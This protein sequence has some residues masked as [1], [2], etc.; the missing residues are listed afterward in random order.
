[1]LANFVDHTRILRL[2]PRPIVAF[3]SASFLRSR[4]KQS[5]FLS[6]FV[7]TQAVECFAEWAI[8][9]GNV[10][11]QRVQQ[12]VFDPRTVGDK[13]KWFSH[14]LECL[15]WSAWDDASSLNSVL[16]GLFNSRLEEPATDES[17][18]DSEAALPTTSTSS[19]SASSS[20]SSLS[21]LVS[22]LVSGE[23]RGSTQL[24]G[25]EDA[26]GRGAAASNILP[27]GLDVS[28]VYRPPKCLQL[29]DGPLEEEDS[30]TCEAEV[31]AAAV[32]AAPSPAADAADAADAAADAADAAKDAA[33]D[34]PP[35]S[36]PVPAE[37]APKTAAPAPISAPQAASHQTDLTKDEAKLQQEELE[38]KE[39]VHE[40]SNEKLRF[41]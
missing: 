20:C 17:G 19:S 33:K 23:K 13:P 29:P 11:Y 15:Q 24:G 25:G 35:S 8:M 7:Q 16:R 30:S 39:E 31:A 32:A 3:Q 37:S 38:K 26:V 10:A 2:Y 9:P 6:Q 28:A 14:E 22:E 5:P 41:T 21:E 18:S 40:S 27:S 12:A 1:M 36:A 4:S 34:A